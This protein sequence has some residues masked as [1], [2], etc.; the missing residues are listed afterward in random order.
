MEGLYKNPFARIMENTLKVLEHSY[1]CLLKVDY[2][3]YKTTLSEAQ[4]WVRSWYDG[5]D[6]TE[7][8][9]QAKNKYRKEGIILESKKAALAC[10]LIYAI[11]I[12]DKY[13]LLD[14]FNRLLT[15]YAELDGNAPVLIKVITNKLQPNHI[16]SLMLR[17]NLWKLSTNGTRAGASIDL[18]FDRGL[19]LL[20]KSMFDITFYVSDDFSTRVRNRGDINVVRNYLKHETENYG[21]HDTPYQHLNLLFQNER[22][23]DDI[24]EIISANNYLNEPFPR[25]D[26]FV[27]GFANYLSELRIKGDTECYT[28]DYFLNKLYD[29]KAFFKKLQGMSK[30]DVTRKNVYVFFRKQNTINQ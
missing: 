25:Y 19:R 7:F 2:T 21:V 6:L 28:L 12:E 22:V 10:N 8:D 16:M 24:R 17:F 18:F 26:Y 27:D 9:S 30:T 13:F 4:K 3:L 23:I 20:L 1:D 29:D 11:K 5:Y 15:D 14:G